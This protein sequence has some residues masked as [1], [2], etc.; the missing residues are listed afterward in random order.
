MTTDA[1]VGV[2]FRMEYDAFRIDV[3]SKNCRPETQ[4]TFQQH[5]LKF[6]QMRQVLDVKFQLLDENRVCNSTPYHICCFSQVF[7]AL[8]FAV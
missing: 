5:K 4:Q 7:R 2:C 3:E 1:C 8:C 6:E